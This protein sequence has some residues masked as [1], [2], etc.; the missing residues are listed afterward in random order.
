[1]RR[2][3]GQ[4]AFLLVTFL[5]RRQR[6]VTLKHV[7]GMFEL[8]PALKAG[9]TIFTTDSSQPTSKDFFGVFELAPALKAGE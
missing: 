1:M 8:A 2:P 5:W 9:G 4:S 7:L 3:T 6:K